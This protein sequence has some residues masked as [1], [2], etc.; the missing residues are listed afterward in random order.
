MASSPYARCQSRIISFGQEY[1]MPGIGEPI[2]FHRA[3][4]IRLYARNGASLIKPEAESFVFR[5]LYSIR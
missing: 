3:A 4:Y 2:L 5:K 1:F